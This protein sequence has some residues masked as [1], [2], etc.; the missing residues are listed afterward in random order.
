LAALKKIAGPHVEFLG[1]VSEAQKMDL[2][3]NA[4]ALIFPGL[5]DFGIVP[6]EALSVATPVVGFGR[7]GLTETVTHL[8]TGVFFQEQ[9]VASLIQALEILE[10]TKFPNENFKK[11]WERFTPEKFRSEFQKAVED[12]ISA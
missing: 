12:S 4:K 11:T 9:T 10:Q 3:K 1:W 6:L 8:H 2:L 7:G 5:E